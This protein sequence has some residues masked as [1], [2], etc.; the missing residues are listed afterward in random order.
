MV[1]SIVRRLITQHAV[2]EEI[3]QEVF[4]RA[5]EKRNGFKAARS[6]ARAWLISIA[7]HRAVDELRRSWR[8][9]A[10][11]LSD[12][13]PSPL[14]IPLADPS[15]EV[16]RTQEHRRVRGA[17]DRLP[18]EQRQVVVLAYF[19]GMTQRQVADYLQQPLGTVKTRTLLALK[20]LQEF[21]TQD[22]IGYDQ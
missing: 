19:Y 15:D 16:G 1:Y 12:D 22:G 13:N 2:A 21:L 11:P 5:W 10:P 6:T 7:H 4:L 9:G 18:P 3:T 17:L 20:K 8:V 14:D